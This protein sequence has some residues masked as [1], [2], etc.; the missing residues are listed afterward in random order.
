MVES[1]RSR[2]SGAPMCQNC[3]DSR[4]MAVMMRGPRPDPTGRT[5]ELYFVCERCNHTMKDRRS[6]QRREG[7][8]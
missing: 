8:R 1:P 6:E 7:P 5:G 2:V 4:G 3:K